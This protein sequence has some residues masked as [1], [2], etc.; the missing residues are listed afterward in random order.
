MGEDEGKRY[1]ID[2]MPLKKPYGICTLGIVD[3]EAGGVIAYVGNER[4]AERI[5]QALETN[6]P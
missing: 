6:E 5:I 2:T 4:N 1:W 3:E